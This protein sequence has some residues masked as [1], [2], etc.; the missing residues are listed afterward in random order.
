MSKQAD[1]VKYPS[2]FASIFDAKHFA[3]SS[4]E[5]AHDTV[6]QLYSSA[7]IFTP[8]TSVIRK[9]FAYYITGLVERLSKIDGDE[10]PFHQ[11]KHTHPLPIQNVTISHDGT[12]ALSTGYDLRILLWETKTGSPQCTLIGHQDWVSTMI[13]SPNDQLVASA[14]YDTTVQLSDTSTGAHRYALKGHSAAVNTIT[15]A[16]DGQILA[17]ASDDATI[18]LWDTT[19]GS[20]HSILRGHTRAVNAISLTSDDQY[21]TSASDDRTVRNWYVASGVDITL[22]GHSN[23]VITV[24]FSDDDRVL[25]STSTDKTIK[26]WNPRSGL[27]MHT[28]SGHSGWVNTT[29]FSPD[30]RFIASASRDKT[31]TIM[32]VARGEVCGTLETV[33]QYLEQESKLSP[34]CIWSNSGPMA[35]ESKTLPQ[36]AYILPSERE[37]DPQALYG[38]HVDISPRDTIAQTA[39]VT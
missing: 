23:R 16:T 11:T 1:G 38:E 12:R 24:A 37:L 13:F 8:T 35:L 27:C 39:R 2:V 14:S 26:I 32:S 21:L 31:I 33:I 15:F 7:L 10:A 9:I 3:L 17:S 28:F 20:C 34:E 25:A 4:N 6:L 29:M 22:A 5:V 36:V 18:K 30:S 19:N